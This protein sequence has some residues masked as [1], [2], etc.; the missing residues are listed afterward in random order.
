MALTRREFVR[1]T[2]LGALGA[3]AAPWLGGAPVASGAVGAD[4]VLV[5]VNLYGGNDGLNTVIPLDQYDRYRELREALRLEP[6]EILSVPGNPDIGLHPALGKLRDLFA[7]D[8]VAILNGV[9]VPES[10]TG[11]FDHDAGQFE[12]QT[13]D[14]QR[15]G[16]TVPTG[17]LGRYLDGLPAS[18]VTPGI[19]LGGGQLILTGHTH[20]PMAI[21]SIDQLGLDLTFD[22]DARRVAYRKI[23]KVSA[24]ESPAGEYNRIV[25]GKALDQSAAVIAA[26]SSYVS[27]PGALYPDSYL[28]RSLGECAKIIPGNLGVR[29]LTV[30]IGGFDTHSGQKNDHHEL[31]QDLG[32]S[33]HAFY[34]DIAAHGLADRVLVLTISEFGRRP[35]E[36]ND[37][38]T[39]HG[40]S[41]V[42]FA[43][44]NPVRRGVYGDYPRL[45][46]ESFVQ[47]G[48]LEVTTDF[49]SVYATAL[50]KFLGVDS[51]PILGGTFAQPSYL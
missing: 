36:N 18:V 3:S 44:G 12:F 7:S 26:T 42:A 39:D 47:D 46:E 13:T 4:N 2:A 15:S 8:R 40:L 11:L 32:D 24:A 29:P 35:Y 31:L 41:S 10:A 17:W 48:N 34:T 14:I 50:E 27:D 49:R 22:S 20:N 51:V 28:G 1:H 21:D 5:I 6:S 9:S 19:D 25:R 37:E 30:G 45:A 43:V 33:V 23:M 38:G 16:L